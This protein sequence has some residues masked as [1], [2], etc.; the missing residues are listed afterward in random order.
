MRRTLTTTLLAAMLVMGLATAA[1]ALGPLYVQDFSDDADGW[2]DSDDDWYGTVTHN[3][4]TGTATFEGDEV[5]APFSPFDGYRATW[6]AGWTAEID[7]YLDPS[8]DAG[9][10]FDYSVA[11]TGTDGL[12]QRD[13]IFHVAKDASENALLVAGSNNTNFAVFEDL[14]TRNHV[15][16][17]DAGWYTL[18]H[19]FRDHNGTLAVDL[20]LLDSNGTVLFTETRNTPADTIPGEVGGNRYGWFTV[21]DVDGGIKVDNHELFAADPENADDCKNGGW[22]GFGFRN[23]GQCIK[24]VNTGKDSR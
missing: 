7:V 16:V 12:H 14:E 2:N 6:T 18:Q 22:D 1:A 19:V 13:F 9:E 17:T 23:Q 24:F 3:P 5:S 8:W 11:A 15:E 4:G 10:G 20:N 21:I